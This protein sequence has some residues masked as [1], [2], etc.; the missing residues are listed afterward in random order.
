MK[1]G[2]IAYAVQREELRRADEVRHRERL[3]ARSVALEEHLSKLED[4][5]ARTRCAAQEFRL[6]L[7]PGV[8][9]DEAHDVVRAQL[10]PVV[11]RI[12]AK[13]EA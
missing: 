13:G 5:L 7:L 10:S 9:E 12:D 11:P 6:E 1:S 8:P 3:A 4:A 2:T